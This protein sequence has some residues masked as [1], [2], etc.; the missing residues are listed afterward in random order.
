MPGKISL[1]PLGKYELSISLSLLKIEK[2]HF[3][4][5]FLSSKMEKIFSLSLSLLEA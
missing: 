2:Q 5:L 4:F 1:S 3:K